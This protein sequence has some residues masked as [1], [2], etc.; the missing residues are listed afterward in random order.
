[1]PRPIRRAAAALAILLSL[2]LLIP[3]FAQERSGTRSVLPI[4]GKDLG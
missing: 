1:M 4:S 2:L 3:A